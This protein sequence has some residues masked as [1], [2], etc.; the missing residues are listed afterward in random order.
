VIAGALGLTSQVPTT[1]AK[2][3]LPSISQV[4]SRGPVDGS[5]YNSQYSSR[6]TAAKA[7]S[8]AS[9]SP[10]GETYSNSSAYNGSISS[11]TSYAPSA[12]EPNGALKTPPPE[13][14]PQAYNR[15]H[16]NSPYVH[17]PGTQAY[18]F[19]SDSYNSM[20]HIG[21]HS[22]VHQSHMA[23]AYQTPATGPPP[24][25][26]HYAPYQPPLLQPGPQ[27]YS[28]APSPYAQHQ[29][30]SQPGYPVSSSMSS[31]LVPSPMALPGLLSL[32]LER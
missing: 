5:W 6:P 16:Q 31:S 7:S 28:S 20:N 3:E 10:R 14:T 11:A 24:A 29:Y 22:D 26:G 25:I 1:N 32:L 12:T 17:Q 27:S 9:S 18:G 8:S 23:T 15:E 21:P 30:G 4:H 13:N 2:L 19:P